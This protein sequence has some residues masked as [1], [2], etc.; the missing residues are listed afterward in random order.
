MR[1][2]A[3]PTG[4]VALA[5]LMTLLIASLAGGALAQAGDA[6]SAPA[7]PSLRPVSSLYGPVPVRS[8]VDGDTIVVSSNVG[9]RTVRL[10]GIDAPEVTSGGRLG[11]RA[12]AYAEALLPVGGLVWLE[13]DLGLEDVYGRLLAYV[14]VVDGNG[15]WD[16]DGRSAT[17]VNLA[18]AEEGWAR[19]LRIEPNVTYA[20][21]YRTA[22]DAAQA[23]EVGIWAKAADSAAGAET[24][25][26]AAGEEAAAAAT[27]RAPIALFCALL[28]P[29]AP[30]DA[31]E[32]VSVLL[33]EPLDTRGYYLYDE[34]SKAVFRLPSGVQ[35]AGELRIHNPGQGVWNNGGDV[36]HLRRGDE[37][38]DRW[39]YQGGVAVEGRV[40]CRD[41]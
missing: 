3:R 40:I 9:P 1:L 33:A 19:T 37:T 20:D 12:K 29:A 17:Q 35:P 26:A 39:A 21:L 22:A 14:Y 13:L 4:R 5:F 38:V 34:G 41:R 32:W 6:T 30:N 8:V 28:N 15:S 23:A 27:D 7:E 31:G 2:W 25:A 10:I 16:L 24:S 11:Q 36:I 18:L